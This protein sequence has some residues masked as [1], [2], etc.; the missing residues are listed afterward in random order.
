[1]RVPFDQLATATVM[2]AMMFIGMR[3][4]YG[5]W[6]WE[7][8]KTWY[9]TRPLVEYVVALQRIRLSLYRRPRDA[10]ARF[11][12]GLVEPVFFLGAF[13]CRAAAARLRRFGHG[14]ETVFTNIR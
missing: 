12:D 8:H 2:V 10:R 13:G 1:M 11:L 5:A 7:V 3:L 4:L 9:H 14:C 6:P